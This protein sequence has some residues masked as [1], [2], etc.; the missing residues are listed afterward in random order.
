MISLLRM[1]GPRPSRA[2][3]STSPRA[4]VTVVTAVALA[5]SSAAIWSVAT[6]SAATPETIWGNSTPAAPAAVDTDPG[7]VELGTRFTAVSNG[8]AT[9]MRFYKTAENRGTH[10]G[11]LWSSTGDLLARTTFSGE[12]SSGWQ[13]ASLSAPVQL[14]A[15]TSY[16][17]SYY[18][19]YGRYT[20]TEWFA[21]SSAS[22][23]L[24]VPS[25]H[26]GVYSYG[27]KSSFPTLTWHASQYWVDLTFSTGSSPTTSATPVASTSTPKATPSASTSATF[28]TTSLSTSTTTTAATTAPATTVTAAGTTAT[29]PTSTAP[30]VTVT[31]ATPKPSSAAPTTSAPNAGGMT[32]CVSL[33]SRCGYPDATNTG[34]RAGTAMLRVPQDVTS[35]PGWQWDS[36]GWLDVRTDGAVV[37]NLIVSG[38]IEAY[39]TNVTIRNNRLLVTGDIWAIGLR[40]T[41][42]ATVANNQIG[43][44]GAPR[45]GVAIKDIYSDATGTQVL[46][47]NILNIGTGIQIT[48]GL[49]EGNYIHDMGIDSGDH[50]N[51]ITSNGSVKQ[52][53]IRGNTILNRFD[54]TD[55]IGLFQDFGVEANRTITGNLLAGGGYTIYGGDNQR[56]GKTYNIKITNNR[57]STIYYPNGGSL[58]PVAYFDR[59]G[60]GNQWTGNIWDLT[61]TALS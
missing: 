6:A 18:T 34:V 44:Q 19:P 37:E 26:I 58:G 23:N 14:T 15:G 28:P 60:T 57:F 7:A 29:R 1:F 9:G 61:G 40:H 21:G 3:R 2:I 4:A 39:G 52:L 51:G 10:T 55:A 20:A 48:Q 43:V 12:T 41:V 31:A 32:N 17:V 56:Y 53:T 54:Q 35:G 24:S 27:S 8:Q 13:T 33:P 42:N 11:S 47:N 30:G 46:R 45:L 25:S 16:V 59:T 22:K 38:P 50:V 5:A 36:R 49:I